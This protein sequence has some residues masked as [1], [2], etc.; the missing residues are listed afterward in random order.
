MQMSQGLQ[1]LLGSQVLAQV[2][3]REGILDDVETAFK[4]A[5]KVVADYY[6]TRPRAPMRKAQSA[7]VAAI[8]E[9]QEDGEVSEREA[10]LISKLARKFGDLV[11]AYDPTEEQV[12]NALESARVTLNEAG[13]SIATA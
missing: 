3:A 1:S 12:T 4:D 6:E 7:F 11:S 8:I 9:Q 2:Q 5:A 10:A 13:Q